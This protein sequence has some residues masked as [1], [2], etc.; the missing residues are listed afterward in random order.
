ML[1]RLGILEERLFQITSFIL[2]PLYIPPVCLCA[3]DESS[4]SYRDFKTKSGFTSP[5]THEYGRWV[6]KNVPAV[7]SLEG[8]LR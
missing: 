4:Y 1:D 7:K 3:N 6:A 2:S 8:S 5:I